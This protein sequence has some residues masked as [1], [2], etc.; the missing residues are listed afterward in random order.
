MLLMI[1]VTN[2]A[3]KYCGKKEVPHILLNIMVFMGLLQ[4]KVIHTCF[5][6]K[7]ANRISGLCHFTWSVSKRKQNHESFLFSYDI[8][9]QKY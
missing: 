7:T 6:P 4:L 3:K 9:V 5:L 8:T 1:A 2:M